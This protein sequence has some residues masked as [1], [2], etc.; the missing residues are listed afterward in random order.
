MSITLKTEIKK[1]ISPNGKYMCLFDAESDPCEFGRVCN[2]YQNIN[3]NLFFLKSLLGDGVFLDNNYLLMFYNNSGYGCCE[4]DSYLYNIETDSIIPLYY[5][6]FDE[7]VV[8][9][10]CRGYFISFSSNILV[11]DLYLITKDEFGGIYFYKKNEILDKKKLN[12]FYYLPTSPESKINKLQNY[13]EETKLLEYC[14]YDGYIRN[15]KIDFTYSTMEPKYGISLELKSKYYSGFALDYHTVSSKL[16]EDRTFDTIRTK[17]GELLYQTKYKENNSV[18]NY[19][20]EV[21]SSFIKNNF[22]SIDIII[23]IPPSNLSRLYQPIFEIGKAISSSTR[24]PIDCEYLIKKTT[25]VQIKGV[26]DN[27][28]RREILKKSFS[29]PDSRYKSKTILLFDDLFRSGETLNAAANILIERGGVEKIYVLT[30]TKTRT[31]R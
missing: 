14:N 13:D 27:E 8:S 9:N 12:Y 22:H 4:G 29:V 30:L 15:K 20:S 11:T 18:I 2:I 26:D 25:G 23:P 5:N 21:A 24:I 16:N 17:L 3:K 1:L 6:S 10:H 7:L 28:T 31:K 19:I